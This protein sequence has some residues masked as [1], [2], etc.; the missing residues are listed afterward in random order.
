M[1]RFIIMLR[2]D[3]G[4]LTMRAINGGLY[5]EDW[6]AV[7]VRSFAGIGPYSREHD[8][9]THTLNPWETKGD[10]VLI[11]CNTNLLY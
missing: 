1:A 9:V 11:T 7:Q 8:S 6:A 5:S 4:T 3:Y 2:W 10:I